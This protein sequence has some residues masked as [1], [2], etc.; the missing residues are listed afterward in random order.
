MLGEAPNPDRPLQGM[1]VAVAGMMCLA[2]DGGQ[3]HLAGTFLGIPSSDIGW[4]TQALFLPIFSTLQ[5][6]ALL[7]KNLSCT[8]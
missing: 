3:W 8:A 4:L 6:F 7:N 5:P 2:G 1:E